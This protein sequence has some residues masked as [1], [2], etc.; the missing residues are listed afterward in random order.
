MVHIRVIQESSGEE[1]VEQIIFETEQKE[2]FEIKNNSK[3]V[4]HKIS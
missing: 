3:V 1:V 2:R 4:N